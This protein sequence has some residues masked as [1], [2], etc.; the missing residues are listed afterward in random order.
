MALAEEGILQPAVHVTE[1]VTQA[2]AL[3]LRPLDPSPDPTHTSPDSFRDAEFGGPEHIFVI[4]RNTAPVSDH[5]RRRLI[6]S[7]PC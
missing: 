2:I 6:G 5:H 1:G 7:R 3:D 4:E